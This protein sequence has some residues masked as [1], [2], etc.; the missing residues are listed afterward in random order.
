MP[1]IEDE[2]KS[3]LRDEGGQTMSELEESLD[4][5][6][7]G[8]KKKTPQQ[9]LENP[10]DHLSPEDQEAA[11]QQHS[12]DDTWQ[13]AEGAGDRDWGIVDNDSKRSKKDGGN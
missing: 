5:I 13:A 11:R 1:K 6:G 8:P 10:N 7:T 12:L 2:T 3:D 4:K 9:L